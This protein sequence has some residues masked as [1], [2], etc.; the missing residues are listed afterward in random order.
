MRVSPLTPTW[1]LASHHSVWFGH[2][3]FKFT[4]NEGTVT[5]SEEELHD[6]AGMIT[7]SKLAASALASPFGPESGV[8]IPTT[9]SM[10][11]V[12]SGPRASVRKY[13]RSRTTLPPKPKP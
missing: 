8:A 3:K 12:A 13:L 2:D 11:K 6:V 10:E 1:L 7:Q 5:G 9:S 4:G